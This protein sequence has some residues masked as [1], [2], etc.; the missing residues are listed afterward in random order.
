MHDNG[1]SE[2]ILHDKFINGD[3]ISTS[4]IE[5]VK[6]HCT[7]GEDNARKYPFLTDVYKV[8]KYHHEKYDGTRFFNIKGEDIPL[9][10][11]IIHMADIIEVNFDLENNNFGVRQAVLDFIK[12]QENIMFSTKIITALCNM[13]KSEEFWAGLKKDFIDKILKK[14]QHNIVW[15]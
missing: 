12:E 4:S 10:L 14:V 6:E 8:I 15:I 9:M 13:V 11:Q 1:V 5:R 7:I 3:L 2:K